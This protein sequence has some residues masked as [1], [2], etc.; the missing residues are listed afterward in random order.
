VQYQQLLPR[1]V[2]TIPSG[3]QELLDAFTTAATCQRL[4]AASSL[5]ASPTS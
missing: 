5:S 4:L 3:G 1:I 2:V